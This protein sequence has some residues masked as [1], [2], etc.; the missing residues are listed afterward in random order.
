MEQVLLQ[1]HVRLYNHTNALL[2]A[3]ARKVIE[4]TTLCVVIIS[5]LVL[6][7]L[8]LIYV[9]NASNSNVN[10]LMSYFE[11]QHLTPN[12]DNDGR[13]SAYEVMKNNYDMIRLN[14]ITGSPSGTHNSGLDTGSDACGTA[15][16]HS[17]EQISW[18][19]WSRGGWWWS[20]VSNKPVYS[21]PAQCESATVEYETRS[22]EEIGTLLG[23]QNCSGS[24]ACAFSTT[25]ITTSAA[26]STAERTSASSTVYLFALERGTLML[27]AD[28]IERHNFTVLDIDVP[29]SASCFG[30]ALP[31]WLASEYLAGY[32]LIV[33]NW[34]IAA[35]QGRGFMYKTLTRE[36]F[37]LNYAGDFAFKKGVS[38]KDEKMSMRL[39]SRPGYYRHLPRSLVTS[40]VAY[41]QQ[42]YTWYISNCWNGILKPHV[43]DNSLLRAL[44]VEP[45]ELLQHI[46]KLTY[47]GV[48]VSNPRWQFVSQSFQQFLQY[49]SFRLGVLF[50]TTFLFFVTTT[51]VSYT[52]RET[53]QRMLRFTY[54][55]QRAITHHQP[56]LP[57]V[58][59]H[60]VESL[61]FVPIMMG[62][63]FFLVGFFSDQLLAFLTMTMVWMGE[64]FSVMNLRTR[65][66][67]KFFPKLFCGYFYL[68]HIYFFSFPFGFSYLAWLVCTLSILHACMHLWNDYEVPAYEQGLINSNTPRLVGI[69]AST[70]GTS[71]TSADAQ[72]YVNRNA[73]SAVGASSTASPSST[74]RVRS[75]PGR[76]SR[77]LPQQQQ[78]QLY[79]SPQTARRS[80][81]AS[82]SSSSSAA[83]PPPVPRTTSASRG[84][85]NSHRNAIGTAGRRQSLS[86][87]TPETVPMAGRSP[88]PARPSNTIRTTT[89]TK[90]EA[91]Q[92]SRQAAR[93]Q[94][95]QGAI[96][97]AAEEEEEEEEEEEQQECEEGSMDTGSRE[98]SFD[99][100]TNYAGGGAT[101]GGATGSVGRPNESL[102][103]SPSPLFYALDPASA[104]SN[105]DFAGSGRRSTRAGAA[106]AIA[107]DNS[108]NSNS[109][110]R[111]N[112]IN[113]SVRSRR[114]RLRTT[115]ECIMGNTSST[116]TTTT[117]SAALP[118]PPDSS[119]VGAAEHDYYGYTSG[120]SKF[121]IS[122][123]ARSKF[124]Q[125]QKERQQQQQK[126]EEEEEEEE[127][128]VSSHRHQTN[129]KI[130]E[131]QSIGG[132]ETIP[133]DGTTKIAL[134]RQDHQGFVGTLVAVE[135]QSLSSAATSTA[136]ISAEAS[137]AVSA[138]ASATA[139]AT[140][141]TAPV[142]GIV[143]KKSV[144]LIA[145]ADCFTNANISSDKG[146]EDSLGISRTVSV[147]SDM[148]NSNSNSN[149]NTRN[150]STD[151]SQGEY[152]RYQWGPSSDY[153]LFFN[154]DGEVDMDTSDHSNQLLLTIAP[155]PPTSA[156]TNSSSSS[157]ICSSSNAGNAAA[158]TTSGSGGSSSNNDNDDDNNNGSVNKDHDTGSTSTGINNNNNNNNN[159]SSSTFDN[160]NNNNNN[161]SSSTFA[162]FQSLFRSPLRKPDP[163]TAGTAVAAT[164]AAGNAADDD[165]GYRYDGVS[166]SSSIAN[167]NS[168]NRG[169]T[170]SEHATS[171]TTRTS[172]TR[173]TST[174]T[175]TAAGFGTADGADGAD[176]AGEFYV[177]STPPSSPGDGGG[178]DGRNNANSTTRRGDNVKA[179]SPS[180]PM[181]RQQQHSTS[182]HLLSGAN[183]FE[184]LEAR[185]IR[186]GRRSSHN[187]NNNGNSSVGSPVATATT[188]C[189]NVS[190]TSPS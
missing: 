61:V 87:A 122:M 26:S 116:S 135:T 50:S 58:F 10:C 40:V 85:K 45:I 129:K 107:V 63:H 166:S 88:L 125:I 37:N 161:N 156:H 133:V 69:I 95:K 65:A 5:F 164:A 118:K 157:S 149:N 119:T 100:M 64:V 144:T 128:D 8:H 180:S 68:F 29:R 93:L 127:E 141:V 11:E 143:R 79:A 22:S 75:S 173:T 130:V 18:A 190:P 158:G 115:S 170:Q 94:T 90:G 182:G 137:E 154:S 152:R 74:V 28:T 162:L 108:S 134:L 3:R 181:E 189:T 168:N 48:T 179:S 131:N 99:T 2:S 20:S 1:Q 42:A 53:Q 111:N 176:S 96:G 123:A 178:G 126:E 15:T 71:P 60:I 9:T 104:S 39:Q 110:N 177:L 73:A 184:T 36:L 54:T 78:Q 24:N 147:C 43:E 49:I 163:P 148:S 41:A 186:L 92:S 153:G 103:P 21:S 139:S 89:T 4:H 46:F 47:F 17:E 76:I 175:A 105:E 155:V 102:S 172:A 91:S 86:D 55:L 59:A 150:Y 56:Y 30:P 31:A 33:M 171:S 101:G 25:T 34:A 146:V 66:S 13:F 183:I 114:R 169:R 113:T 97:N 145:A 174:C 151:N 32:D 51:L 82:N 120:K 7:V 44:L 167:N 77:Q 121:H 67:I 142:T 57:L 160:N 14:I 109:N 19:E 83:A 70:N 117:T 106:S 165:M 38:L 62:I 98:T 185:R 27:A 35:F 6:F 140:V 80:S 188:S 72:Q 16:R 52:L 23:E 112:N 124:L 187:N 138:T 136:H 84:V 132:G 12:H 81:S 159:N